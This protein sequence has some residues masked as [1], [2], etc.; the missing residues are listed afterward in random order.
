MKTFEIILKKNI[1]PTMRKDEI[2]TKY[3]DEKH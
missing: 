2:Q 3:T 1:S